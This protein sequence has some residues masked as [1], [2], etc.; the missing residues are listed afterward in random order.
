MAA[1][2]ILPSHDVRSGI[3]RGV[4][5]A[6]DLV[7]NFEQEQGHSKVRNA[8]SVVALARFLMFL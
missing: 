2:E 7:V 8:P 3:R 4:L 5:I 1:F 6:L